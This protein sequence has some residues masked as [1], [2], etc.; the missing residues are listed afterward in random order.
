MSR[1]RYPLRVPHFAAG[2][3]AQETR[4]GIGRTW[5]GARWLH[6]LE[7]MQLGARLARG[8]VYATAGQITAM[9]MRGPHIEASVV[10]TRPE[11]YHVTIDFRTPEGKARERIIAAIRREPI[12]VARLLA[13]DL[14]M[15]VED[16]FRA[17]GFTLFSGGKLGPGKYDITSACSC[18]DYANPCKHSCAVLIIFG[19]E[20]ARRP[21]TLLE[22][23]GITM[24]DLIDEE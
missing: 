8:R 2:I 21:M 20:A 9:T 1:K 23:R 11:P 18:P 3:R 4:A 19:E 15:Q 6:T 16:I 17:E 24:K 12:F 5:W 10:G 22:A 7:A 14:P 13:D